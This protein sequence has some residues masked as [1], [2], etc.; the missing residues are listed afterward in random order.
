M[1]L[2]MLGAA[3]SVE[4]SASTPLNMNATR[5]VS[6]DAATRTSAGV[7]PFPLVLEIAV[8]AQGGAAFR[9]QTRHSDPNRSNLSEDLPHRSGGDHEATVDDSQP[10]ASLL[11]LTQQVGVEEP[12]GAPI[13]QLPNDPP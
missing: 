9:S 6:C 1:S 2:A 10:I 4:P 12:R 3:T 11:R 7:T 13:F 5:I 8:G